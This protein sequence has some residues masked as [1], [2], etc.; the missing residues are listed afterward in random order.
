MLGRVDL[1]LPGGQPEFGGVQKAG[2]KTCVI[3]CPIWE[4]GKDVL[5]FRFP[6]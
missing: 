1:E 2:T 6:L 3:D 4:L 5:T